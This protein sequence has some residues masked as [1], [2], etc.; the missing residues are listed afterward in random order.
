[1]TPISKTVETGGTGFGS[2]S[3]SVS[4]VLKPTYP[5]GRLR[6]GVWFPPIL[7]ATKFLRFFDIGSSDDG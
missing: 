3:S 4:E 5:P 2:S 6:P 7:P 1:M